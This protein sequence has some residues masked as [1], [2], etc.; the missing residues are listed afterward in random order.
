MPL[1]KYLQGL[2]MVQRESGIGDITR[3]INAKEAKNI[4]KRASHHLFTEVDY[5]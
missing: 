5:L 3:F 2:L 4:F 1:T